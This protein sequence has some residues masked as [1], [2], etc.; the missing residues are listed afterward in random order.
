[1][2][3]L[4][5]SAVIG[6]FTV[7]PTGYDTDDQ[8]FTLQRYDT[9]L[10]NAGH[11]RMHYAPSSFF[12]IDLYV[13]TTANN[14]TK[15][16]CDIKAPWPFT[17]WGA[18]V[19]C[20]TA[21]SAAGT[22]DIL[23]DPLGAQAYVSILDAAEDVKTQEGQGQRVAPEDGS[24]DIVFGTSIICRQIASTAAAMIGGQA[25]LYCQRL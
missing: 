4:D 20:E 21:A 9:A 5:N 2:A 13:L 16:S 12:V 25:H 11:D 23:T 10:G 18:D 22:V 1:M 3:E 17:I 19:G 14:N 24:E 8:L 7:R 15:D 6:A